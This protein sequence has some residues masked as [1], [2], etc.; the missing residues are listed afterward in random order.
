MRANL[1]SSYSSALI[2]LGQDGL[3]YISSRLLYIIFQA[4]EA[5]CNKQMQHYYYPSTYI[6]TIHIFHYYTIN[7]MVSRFVLPSFT[8][9]LFI[10]CMYDQH[11]R[12]HHHLSLFPK[13]FQVTHATVA[14]TFTDCFHPA[15]LG[16]FE[17]D[18]LLLLGRST[19]RGKS[20]NTHR[21]LMD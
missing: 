6:C 12:F 7:E 16:Q 2:S 11:L 5:E 18:R 4:S 20:R 13:W 10:L 21:V 3:N 8:D 17:I 1:Y 9:I 14:A 19:S 15:K